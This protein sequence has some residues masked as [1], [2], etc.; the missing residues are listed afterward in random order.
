MAYKVKILKFMSKKYDFMAKLAMMFVLAMSVM[1]FIRNPL[2]THDRLNQALWNTGHLFFFALLVVLLLNHE[3]L[4]RRS[5]SAKLL[6]SV[7]LSLVLG[8]L[9]E[10]VQYSVGRYMALED[11]VQ[12]MLGGLLGF[13]VVFYFTDLSE[14]GL[15]KS[16]VLKR[17]AT[18]TLLILTVLLAFYP[19]Y[20][21]VQDNRRMQ[22]DFPLLAGFEAA[23]ELAR[24]DSDF[25]NRMRLDQDTVIE[26]VFS[27]FVEFGVSEYS[28]I[29][30]RA[31][32]GDWRGYDW[33]NFSIYNDQS[34][35]LP[36]ELKI[37]DTQHA[38]NGYAYS[39][40]FNRLLVLAPGWNDVEVSLQD[41]QNAA[42][43]RKVD[44]QNIAV[45]SLFVHRP[46]EPLRIYLDNI[47][48]SKK[49]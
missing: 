48:L 39:D 8:S 36:I 35:N 34:D 19:A 32:A 14:S 7:L 46:S 47:H 15:F 40:R 37:F 12:D 17:V 24:W 3:S 27:L 31:L 1:L 28:D 30:L 18:G 41:I 44:L 49:E 42:R 23:D 6:F 45:V 21:I 2:E 26:G 10:V 4:I 16:M 20:K 5:W 38:G 11:V 9:I 29:T 43:S 33:L 22:D 13:F 25:V